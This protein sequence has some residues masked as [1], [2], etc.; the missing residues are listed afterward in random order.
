MVRIPNIG[1]FYSRS[2]YRTGEKVIEKK[3]KIKIKTYASTWWTFSTRWK[4]EV[5]LFKVHWSLVFIPS[6][7]L[8][9]SL[10]L[11]YFLTYFHNFGMVM[12]EYLCH[13]FNRV[14][15][16]GHL[17]RLSSCSLLEKRPSR[18]KKKKRSRI[19]N[20]WMTSFPS[21]FYMYF[22]WS[23]TKSKGASVKERTSNRENA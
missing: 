6:C 8:F 17:L 20:A 9:F 1:L 18:R 21:S 3:K 14:H 7:S 13:T 10:F 23:Q 11:L 12:R 15:V 16:S 4:A 22:T 19:A 2:T 5:S